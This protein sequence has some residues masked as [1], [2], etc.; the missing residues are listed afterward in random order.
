MSE[1]ERGAAGSSCGVN[2][3]AQIERGYK[4]IASRR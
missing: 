2:A 3:L 4:E 1:A